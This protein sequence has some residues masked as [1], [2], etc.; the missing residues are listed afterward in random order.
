MIKGEHYQIIPELDE[1]LRQKKKIDIKQRMNR[2]R[3]WFIRI[4]NNPGAA[5]MDESSQK[6]YIALSND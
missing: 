4:L 3:R 6:Y 1:E 5:V 2:Q